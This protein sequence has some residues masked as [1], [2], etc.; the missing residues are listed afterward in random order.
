MKKIDGVINNK[1]NNSQNAVEV[2]VQLQEIRSTIQN[3][4]VTGNMSESQYG[5]LTDKISGYLK[6]NE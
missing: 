6:S 2:S 3:A 4:L 1:R 5:I